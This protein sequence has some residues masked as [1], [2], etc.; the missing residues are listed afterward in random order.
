MIAWRKK[1]RKKKRRRQKLRFTPYAWA[2]LRFLRD[3]GDTEVGG[4]G[5]SHVDDLLLIEDF[6]LV[7]QTCT[8]VTVEFD[9]IAVADAVATRSAT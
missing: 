3:V 7:K 6:Q 2:K 1:R 9:D 8:P 5:I 4:F